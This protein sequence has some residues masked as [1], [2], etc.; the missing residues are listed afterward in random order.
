M[1]IQSARASINQ[2]LI[3]FVQSEGFFRFYGPGMVGVDLEEHA[4]KEEE[5]EGDA[6]DNEDIGNVGYA[7]GGEEGHLLFCGAH[8][9]EAGCVEELLPLVTGGHV[10]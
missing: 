5:E 4:D 6:V 8:E 7:E 3:T 10:T 2:P 9:K 1:A